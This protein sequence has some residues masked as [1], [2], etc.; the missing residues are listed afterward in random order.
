MLEKDANAFLKEFTRSVLISV[1]EKPLDITPRLVRIEI[2]RI[3]TLI[4]KNADYN[5]LSWYLNE[6]KCLSSDLKF[7]WGPKSN[8]NLTCTSEQLKNLYAGL[9]KHEFID[10]DVTSE[11]DFLK[12]FLEDWYS[13]N[14][15]CA[16]N[17]DH[18]QTNHFL[19]LFNKSTGCKPN[20]TDIEKVKNIINNNGHI[21]S[22]ALSAAASR[23]RYIGP[24]RDSDLID[25][26]SKVNR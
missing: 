17:M 25:A 24:K 6:L 14:S 22:S 8:Y 23:N 9:V 21:K 26:F 3:Q 18:P 2:N 11:I 7:I 1:R 20:L 13:H 12:V 15:I 4:L 10:I 5:F 16:L 19:Q